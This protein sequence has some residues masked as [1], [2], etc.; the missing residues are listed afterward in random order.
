M[1]TIYE[2]DVACLRHP[3]TILVCGATGSGKTV[4]TGNLIEKCNT[5][6]CPSI[7][8]V[9]YV[10]SI[11]QPHFEVIQQKSPVPIQFFNNLEEI[12]NTSHLNCLL[13][14]DDFMSLHRDS[15]LEKNI[16]SYFIK[17]SHHENISCAY[18]AQNLFNDSKTHRTISL[19][20]QYIF[21][22]KNPRAMSQVRYLASQIYPGHTKFLTDAY[23]DATTQPYG[24]L[25]LD[26]Q[27][28]TP[29]TLRV[30]TDILNQTPVVYVKPD[31]PTKLT[32]SR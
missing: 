1:N 10:Y 7:E 31:T 23:K 21:L 2:S 25:M 13:V 17:R 4:L 16:A 5:L 20:S 6:F 32:R 24:Y 27:Q 15:E 22:L 26:F 9:Y 8:K 19:N 12:P 28:Q 29:E 30:R 3:C 11:M 14:I 18:L